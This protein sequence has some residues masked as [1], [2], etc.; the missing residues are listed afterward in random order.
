MLYSARRRSEISVLLVLPSRWYFCRASLRTGSSACTVKIKCFKKRKS[1]EKK[2]QKLTPFRI[3]ISSGGVSTVLLRH[4]KLQDRA[5]DMKQV[6][7]K[8]QNPN[9]CVR[10]AS[11]MID[12]VEVSV[13]KYKKA[14]R[15]KFRIEGCN[16]VT[17][18]HICIHA[19]AWGVSSKLPV[20]T[21]TP[22][23]PL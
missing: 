1:G 20:S 16:V 15:I 7:K 4:W 10:L 21:F 3:L 6:W 9:S 14:S 22:P 11:G 18:P 5:M 23:A 12:W 8:V 17:W 19:T 2:D 13:F